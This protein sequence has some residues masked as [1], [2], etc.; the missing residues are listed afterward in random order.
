MRTLVISDLHLGLRSEA[1]VLR[2]DPARD[3]LAERLDG[4]ERLVLLGDTLELR[5]GPQRD[6]VAAAEPALRALGHA[7]GADA[8]VV[9]VPGN[10]DH[11][12]ISGWLEARER[13]APA[14]PMGLEER[15]PAADASAAAG[16]L[17]QFLGPDRVEVAYPGLWLRE[18]VYATHGH[19]LDAHA[20]VPTFERLGA[21]IMARLVGTIGEPA[22]P[23]EYEAQLAPMYAWIHAAAQRAGPERAAAGSGSAVKAWHLLGAD[24]RRTL[25]ARVLGGLFPLAILALNKAGVG[26]VGRDISGAELRRSALRAMGEAMRRL[27]MSPAHLV[28][29]HTHRTGRLQGDQAAEWRAGDTEL[30]NSGCWV[31][32]THFMGEHPDPSHPYWPGGAIAVDPGGPPRLERLLA[33]LPPSALRGPRPA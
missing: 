5:H 10:H 31:F 24:G 21:G 11:A 18:D 3:V 2:R 29:G 15:V 33:G 30:H 16:R 22:T 25:R 12:L 28:F 20:T 26:P 17:A 23:D 27:Q 13:D 1:D 4:V 8:Q 32:E 6:A 7:L 19:Y 9:L 14:P